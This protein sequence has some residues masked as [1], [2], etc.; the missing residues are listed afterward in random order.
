MS[1]IMFV[2]HEIMILKNTLRSSNVT[3]YLSDHKGV[4]QV[5]LKVLVELHV[6]RMEFLP[7]RDR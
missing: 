4:S 2:D 3:S 7:P 6:S 1:S 5:S